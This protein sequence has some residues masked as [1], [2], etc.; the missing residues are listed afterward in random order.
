MGVNLIAALWGFA[1]ATLFFIVPDV[2]LT[3]AGRN[4]LRRG[5]IACFYSLAGALIGGVA[6]YLWAQHDPATA[7]HIVEKIP[8]I[9]THMALGVREALS[10]KGVLA[11]MLGPLSGTPYKLYAV[12]AA[13]AGIGLGLFLLISLPA[14][15]IRFLLVTIISHYAVAGLSGLPPFHNRGRVLLIAWTV[16]YLGYFFVM[17][18]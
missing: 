17:Q 2:W 15:L 1:E 18:E 7:L 12:Q 4:N 11:V 10:D 9:S 6:M 16:F 8:A 3:L 5:I 14:R 13:P